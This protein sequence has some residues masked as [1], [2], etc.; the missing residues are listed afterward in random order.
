MIVKPKINI[1]I[2]LNLNHNKTYTV[3][4]KYISVM[5]LSLFYK[6][7]NDDLEV[8]SYPAEWFEEA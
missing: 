5:C 1:A 6:I 3:I 7:M 2:P 4:G 8:S